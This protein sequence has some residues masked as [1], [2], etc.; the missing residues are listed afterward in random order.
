M[1][2]YI[3]LGKEK[4]EKKFQ[5]EATGIYT[6]DFFFEAGRI[7]LQLAKR[8]ETAFMIAMIEVDDFKK[9]QEKYGNQIVYKILALTAK[10]I[11]E[12]FRNSDIVADMEDGQIGVIFYNT[13]N[14]NSRIAL[15]GLRKK[16]EESQYI[17]NEEKINVTVSIGGVVMHNLMSARSI[18]ILYEQAKT[19]L[20]IARKKGKNNVVIY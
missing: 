17:L 19:G 15:E 5:N 20:E 16:V 2:E 6:K 10:I 3:E 7:L 12:K 9:M 8:H 14:V 18:E 4:Q 13:N 11:G 1:M